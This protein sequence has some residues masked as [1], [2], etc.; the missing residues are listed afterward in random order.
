MSKNL[1]GGQR[2]RRGGVVRDKHSTRKEQCDP[3]GQKG[4]VHPMS[5][6]QGAG[7]QAGLVIRHSRHLA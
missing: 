4:T 2:K 1:S 7:L 3:K 5:S 6:G